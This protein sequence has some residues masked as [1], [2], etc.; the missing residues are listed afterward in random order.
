MCIRDRTYYYPGGIKPMQELSY[1]DGRLNGTTTKYNWRPHKVTSKITYKNGVKDGKMIVYD[2][3][4]RVAIE[5]T[6][7]EGIEVRADGKPVRFSP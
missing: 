5:K 4:G 6:F 2:K 1:K 7:K 3:R